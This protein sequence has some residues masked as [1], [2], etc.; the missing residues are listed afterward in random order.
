[1]KIELII[2]SEE[3]WQALCGGKIKSIL[4]HNLNNLRNDLKTHLNVTMVDEWCTEN[5]SDCKTCAFNVKNNAGCLYSNV[6]NDE[7]AVNGCALSKYYIDGD[8]LR[9]DWAEKRIV[10]PHYK[11]ADEYQQEMSFEELKAFKKELN[12]EI[13]D[14]VLTQPAVEKHNDNCSLCSCLACENPC[15]NCITCN[16]D[17]V[18]DEHKSRNDNWVENCPDGD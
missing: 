8:D 4:H 3:T 6:K 14:A 18:D 2:E 15:S 12:K 17:I 16:G 13:I 11:V 10:C 5:E 1:M 9:D 7:T